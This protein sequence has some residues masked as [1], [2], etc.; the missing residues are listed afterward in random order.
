MKE[1]YIRLTQVHEYA[2]GELDHPILNSDVIESKSFSDIYD[3]TLVKV[4][5]IKKEGEILKME[6]IK[7]EIDWAAEVRA[8]LIEKGSI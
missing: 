5:E 2:D 3:K 1:E 6:D 4:E 8:S 7:E